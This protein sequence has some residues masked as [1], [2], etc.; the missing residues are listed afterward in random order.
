MSLLEWAARRGKPWKSIRGARRQLRKPTGCT[1]AY[2]D[3]A[4][5]YQL[6]KLS[7]STLDY[8][9]AQGESIGAISIQRRNR[10][11][12]AQISVGKPD[13][14][15]MPITSLDILT[16]LTV[17]DGEQ[18][19]Q[20]AEKV[21]SVMMQM[22]PEDRPE[23]LRMLTEV[24][25]LTG[26]VAIVGEQALRRLRDREKK[27]RKRACPPPERATCPPSERATLRPLSPARTGHFQFPSGASTEQRVARFSIARVRRGIEI[28][29]P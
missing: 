1:S 12:A 20:S 26:E 25:A 11:Q 24:H 17:V 23:F 5:I 15:L 28:G 16:P 10:G 3:Y 13:G 4:D 22:V 21:Y 8:W 29:C 14:M 6:A 19:F 2:S 7:R 27:R 9:L 18:D